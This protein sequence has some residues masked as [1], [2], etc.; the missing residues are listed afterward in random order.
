MLQKAMGKG[1]VIVNCGKGAATV[2]E[3]TLRPYHKLPQYQKAL[4]SN[5]NVVII[6]LGT[7]DANPKWWD[8]V[9]RKT[10]FDGT[11]AEE[12]KSRYLALIDSF[13]KL[14]TQPRIILATPMPIFPEVNNK[15]AGRRLHLINDVIPII[16]Q[17]SKERQVELVDLQTEMK[18]QKSNCRDGVHYNKAGYLAMAKRFKDAIINDVIK[19]RQNNSIDSDKK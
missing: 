5:P 9:K 17:I 16:H 14:P 4:T 15:Q 18:D 19:T 7:N 6:M 8:D 11:P 13:Q 12:F 10:S 1:W 3:G 2:I